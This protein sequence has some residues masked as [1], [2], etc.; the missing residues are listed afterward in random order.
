GGHGARRR[1]RAA[2]PDGGVGVDLFAALVRLDAAGWRTTAPR[3]D[4]AE[5]A[6]TPTP[7]RL[8]RRTAT[9][10]PPDGSPPY[11]FTGAPEPGF[12]AGV[13][14]IR[15]RTAAD[16]E[17]W[18]AVHDGRTSVWRLGPSGPILVARRLSDWLAELVAGGPG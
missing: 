2:G 9:L 4:R 1:D 15:L 7:A 11:D 13:P 6:P 8:L 16:G 14:M 5:V 10:A 3:P 18:L 17:T 12:A